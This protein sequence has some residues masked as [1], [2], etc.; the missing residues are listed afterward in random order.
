MQ[1][2]ILTWRNKSLWLVLEFAA[3]TLSVEQQTQ[4]LQ[5]TRRLIKINIYAKYFSNSTMQN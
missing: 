4:V 2:K 5:T 1:E 3:V